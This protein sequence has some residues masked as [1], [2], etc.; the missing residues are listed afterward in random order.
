MNF[1][2]KK[3]CDHHGMTEHSIIPVRSILNEGFSNERDISYDLDS[4]LKCHP[5]DHR[6]AGVI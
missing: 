2:A 4:C 1:V 5:E 6:V 3:Y